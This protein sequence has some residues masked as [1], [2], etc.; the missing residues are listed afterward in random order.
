MPT[1]TTSNV[2]GEHQQCPRG[3]DDM[4]SPERNVVVKDLLIVFTRDFAGYAMK[5]VERPGGHEQI[6]CLFSQQV[7]CGCHPGPRLKRTH[8]LKK[9]LRREQIYSWKFKV[10]Y[11]PCAYL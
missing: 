5:I 9:Q 4:A 7:G 6:V 8:D 3:P 2:V 1:M 10:S 11:L